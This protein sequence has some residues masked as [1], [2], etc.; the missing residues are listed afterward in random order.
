MSKLIYSVEDDHDI[1][2]IVNKTLTRQGYT[3]KSFSDGK[4]FFAAFK[5][6]KPH[7][8]LLDLMLPDMSGSEIL[9]KIRADALNDEIQIIIIS[10]KH[11]VTDKVENLDLGADDYI[12]KP[13][14]LLELMARVDAK[15]RRI[16]KSDVIQ[17][18]DVT[19]NAKERVVMKNGNV[20][21]LTNREFS[22]LETLMKHS[23]N[24]ISR[25]QLFGIIWKVEQAFESRTLDMH[26]KALREKLKDDGTFIKTVY[27]VGY[28]I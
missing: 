9:K 4:S 15:M 8:I 1:A 5:A 7:L 16:D 25:E 12:E 19:L 21:E 13:F 11:L 20:V 27:G 26:I 23:P 18:G 6:Q 17:V 14:D 28:K 22:I 2:L 3:V 10:A 24:V